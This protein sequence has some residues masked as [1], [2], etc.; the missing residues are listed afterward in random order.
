MVRVEGAVNFLGGRAPLQRGCYV[1]RREPVASWQSAAYSLFEQVDM[2]CSHHAEEFHAV[3]GHRFICCTPA[4]HPTADFPWR[5]EGLALLARNAAEAERADAGAH[6][7]PNADAGADAG[8][9]AARARATETTLLAYTWHHRA[10]GLA[11]LAHE[12]P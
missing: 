9:N 7:D 2:H 5:A 4:Y 8:A 12:P 6:A 3:V 1:C 10:A 11:F